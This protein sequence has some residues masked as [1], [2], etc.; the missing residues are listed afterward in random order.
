MF[1]HDETGEKWGFWKFG[2]RAEAGTGNGTESEEVSEERKAEAERWEAAMGAED[3]PEFAGEWGYGEQ[4]GGS[5]GEE[6]EVAQETDEQET[7]E[8]ELADVRKITSYGFDT[9]SRRYGLE[10]VINTIMETDEIVGNAENPLGVIYRALIPSADERAELYREIRKDNDRAAKYNNEEAGCE[11][12]VL[13]FSPTGDFYDKS[14]KQPGGEQKSVEAI[15]VVRK[16]MNTLEND[17]RFDA[18]REK[19]YEQDQSIIECLMGETDRPTISQFLDN[20]G[21]LGGDGAEVSE[22]MV[23]EVLEEIEEKEEEVGEGGKTESG[24]EVGIEEEQVS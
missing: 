20:I 14:M 8:D 10:T 19:A 24:N 2:R 11:G 3:T 16:L 21:A 7:V 23:D 5:E 12:E 22:G 18:L 15:R 6:T 13:G 4:G 17:E 9:A 1:K